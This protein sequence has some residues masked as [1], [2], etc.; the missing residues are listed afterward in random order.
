MELVGTK[1]H[2]TYS[3]SAF[4]HYSQNILMQKYVLYLTFGI[5]FKEVI[6]EFHKTFCINGVKNFTLNV[7]DCSNCSPQKEFVSRLC[8]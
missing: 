3:C 5:Y 1:T 8:Y 7:C 6:N 4:C 2:M